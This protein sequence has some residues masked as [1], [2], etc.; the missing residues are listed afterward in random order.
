MDDDLAEFM[1]GLNTSEG[2][3]VAP[4]VPELTP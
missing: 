2:G 1:S 3:T 4:L